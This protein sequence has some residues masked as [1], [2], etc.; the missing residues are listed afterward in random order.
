[1]KKHLAKEKFSDQMLR[2][3]CW[4]KICNKTQTSHNKGVILEGIKR[5]PL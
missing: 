3:K 4:S 1:M 5:S 2:D